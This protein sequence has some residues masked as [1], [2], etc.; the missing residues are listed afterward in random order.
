[1]TEDGLVVKQLIKSGNARDLDFPGELDVVHIH[2]RLWAEPSQSSSPSLQSA[3][4]EP[5]SL[6]ATASKGLQIIADTPGD[7]HEPFRHILGD[8]LRR[9]MCS[10]MNAVLHTMRRGEVSNTPTLCER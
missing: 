1:M 2:F 4:D 5:G 10:G 8:P 7:P 3:D 6:R 9:P